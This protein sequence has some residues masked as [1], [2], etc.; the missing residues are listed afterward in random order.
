M[1]SIPRPR[2]RVAESKRLSVIEGSIPDMLFPPKGCKFHPR[3][4]YAFDKC[5][6]EEPELKEV[7]EGRKIAC[8]L[9]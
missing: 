1:K 7:T 2:K 8:H 4:P 6:Q 5:K 3:C 9:Y